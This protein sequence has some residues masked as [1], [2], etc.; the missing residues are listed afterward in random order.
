MITPYI[1]HFWDLNPLRGLSERRLI[2]PNC[3]LR[4]FR[5]QTEVLSKGPKAM[6]LHSNLFKLFYVPSFGVLLT[7]HTVPSAT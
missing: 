5:N 7:T 6:I 1:C 4:S 2:C 3:R